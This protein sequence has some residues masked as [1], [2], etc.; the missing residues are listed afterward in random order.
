M[1]AALLITVLNFVYLDH[2]FTV[3]LDLFTFIVVGVINLYVIVLFKEIYDYYKETH[4]LE[5]T[6][7]IIY[8]I[9]VFVQSMYIHRY[10][11][12]TYDKVFL[13]SYFI[14]ASALA[15]L[16]GFRNKLFLVRKLGLGAI[17]FSLIK[18]FTYD[19]FG[20]EFTLTVRMVTYFILGLLLMAIAFMYSYLEKKYGETT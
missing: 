13:S 20:A 3:G 11:N 17:Y 16:Y 9:G 12:F 14:I 2:D 8:L 15:I 7:I 1:F 10:I 4:D 19:F 6:F 18:F 5:K